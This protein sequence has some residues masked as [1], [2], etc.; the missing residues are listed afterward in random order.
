MKKK[1]VLLRCL[2]PFLILFHLI[3]VPS[4]GQR[5]EDQMSARIRQLEKEIEKVLEETKTP[6]VGIALVNEEGP[7][8]IAGIGIADLEK[9]RKADE[10]TMFRIGSTSK[11]F[12][13]LAIL[14]L[15]EEGHLSL[16][17]KV[18]DLVPE[19]EFTNRWEETNPILVEYLLEHTTGWDDIHLPEY[20]HNDS[21]PISIKEALEYHPHSRN[22]RW[23]PGTRMSYCNSGAAVAAYIVEQVSGKP[24]ETYIQEIFFSPM[25]MESMTYFQSDAYRED[26]ATLYKSGQPQDYWHIMVRPSGSINASPKDMA[27]MVQFFVNR[28]RVDSLQLLGEASLKR[29]EISSTT[30]GARA[31]MTELGYG[32]ANYSSLFNRFV[33]RSHQGGANGGLS[34]LSYLPEHKLGYSIQINSQS[35]EALYRIGELIRK[36]QTQSLSV[37]VY[38]LPPQEPDQQTDLSGY[39]MNISPRIQMW[40]FLQRF[41]QMKQISHQGNKLIIKSF[42]GGNTETYQPLNAKF[43]ASEGFNKASMAIVQDPLEGEIVQIGSDFWK[44]TSP[45]LVFA[46]IGLLGLWVLLMISTIIMGPIWIVRYKKGRLQGGG[47][48]KVRLWPYLTSM[49]FIMWVAVLFVGIGDPLVYLGRVS[50][51]SVS[52]MLLSIAFALGA[53]WSVVY[54]YKHRRARINRFFYWYSAVLATLHLMVCMY[55]LWFGV[56]GW[57]TW[58]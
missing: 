38:N 12:A 43:Y 42:W 18:R 41:I 2:I 24:Y 28:G 49:L 21:V 34:D 17:D 26:G 15:Q 50:L 32:L 51:V 20:A 7:V 8:W 37:P 6:A 56:I 23:V 44:R 3:V 35:G 46:P 33:Y 40:Y 13:A 39:Y 22:A 45:R 19:I 16:Q 31:G 36:F 57:Q 55:L 53:V 30:L 58:S 48:L 29:M 5:Q 11:M 54:V 27:R 47:N 9:N 25:G 52:I 1:V 4:F 14:K 10:N